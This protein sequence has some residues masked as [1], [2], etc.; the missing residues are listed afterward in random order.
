LKGGGEQLRDE[1]RALNPAALVPTLI[2]DGLVLTQSLAILEYLEERWPQVPLLPS[3]AAGRARVRALALTIACEIHPLN[4][5]RVLKYLGET[6]QVAEDARHE[7]YRHWTARGLEVLE[8]HLASEPQTGAFCH[9]DAPTLADCCL[10]PQVFNARRFEIDLAAYPTVRR[11][12]DACAGLEAF[13]AADP[14]RQPD[15]E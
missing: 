7:W 11:I 2:D 12:A 4:N 9:G 13:R 10:V 1:Y 8:R 5:L 3:D 6:L 14:A 15:A